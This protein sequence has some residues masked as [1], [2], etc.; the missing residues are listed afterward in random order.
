MEE[1]LGEPPR[2]LLR[3]VH[4]KKLLPS[5]GTSTLSI[6]LLNNTFVFN[7]WRV[8]TVVFSSMLRLLFAGRWYFNI[9]HAASFIRSVELL[10]A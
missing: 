5:D 8:N 3:A 7:M 4:Q 1:F 6:S 10:R 2:L 9:S